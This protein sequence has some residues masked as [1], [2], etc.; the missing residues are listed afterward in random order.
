[1]TGAGYSTPTPIQEAAIPALLDNRDVVGIAQ[2]GTGKTAAFV[3]PILNQILHAHTRPMPNMCGALI[4]APTRELAAQIHDNI[5]LYGKYMDVTSTLVVGG[6]K[7]QKQIRAL[8][9]GVNILVATPGRLEDHQSTGAVRLDD[10]TIVVLDE[11][12]QM[13]DM[14][15]IPAIRRIMKTLPQKR[16]TV[17]FSATMPKQIR[18]LA[19]DFLN[20]PSEISVAPASKPI[21]RIEQ[22][23]LHVAKAEKRQTLVD[24]LNK[25]GTDRAIVFTRTKHG[26]NKV[27]QHLEKSGLTA[28][29]IHG[30]KSQGQRQ[31]ALA[32]FK[33]GEIKILVAT[34]I[35]ARGI[36][37]D[38][39]SH[40]IN[41]ELP[42]VPEVYIHRIGR[43]ARAGTSGIAISLCDPE[44]RGL[45][46][47]IEKLIGRSFGGSP[48]L[49]KSAPS[50]TTR[51][52]E[53][54]TA[55][56]RR[57][58]RRKAKKR[59]DQR[60]IGPKHEHAQPAAT[61]D[62]VTRPAQHAKRHGKKSSGS[63]ARSGQNRPAQNRSGQKSTGRVHSNRNNTHANARQSA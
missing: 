56:Q 31:R 54:L 23:V 42:N 34:D 25:Q 44:E 41:F 59:E 30:N 53:P 46:R 1:M 5:R 28:D 16:Q 63:N 35:A 62:A 58:Q 17:L 55:T 2:T 40:V 8:A 32:G 6:V 39:I 10:T 43:T 57:N 48:V 19:S 9:R 21:D 60:A 22:I 36:D 49:P 50:E 15:F 24:L 47:D 52:G 7:P 51:G 61:A 33:A 38:G 37:V 13:L 29:A 18:S 14:G 3:L 4:L 11:A 20:K 27:A 12:D 45:L 26:A